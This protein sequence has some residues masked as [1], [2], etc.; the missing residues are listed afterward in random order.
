MST[1][2][3][4][5][6]DYQSS[7]SPKMNYWFSQPSQSYIQYKKDGAIS[8]PKGYSAAGTDDTFVG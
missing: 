2:T 7:T 3:K 1:K 6:T 8:N 4:Q 5:N